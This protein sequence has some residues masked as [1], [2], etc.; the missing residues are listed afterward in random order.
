MKEIS[1]DK[2]ILAI[3]TL[4]ETS[5]DAQLLLLDKAIR[6]VANSENFADLAIPEIRTTPSSSEG[7][8]MFDEDEAESENIW[9]KIL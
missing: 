9:G 1:R 3:A 7:R 5:G 6:E 4:L 2:I 8:P